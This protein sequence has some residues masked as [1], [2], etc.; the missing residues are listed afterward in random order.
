MPHSNTGPPCSKVTE[1]RISSP[2]M[3]TVIYSPTSTGW[4]ISSLRDEDPN[5]TRAIFEPEDLTCKSF[6]G[7]IDPKGGGSWFL[8]NKNSNAIVLLNG[9]YQNHIPQNNY[10]KSRGLIV[11]ELIQEENPLTAWQSTDLYQIEPFTLVIAA[12]GMLWQAVWDGS[13]KAIATQNSLKAHIWSSST[14]YDAE[15][16]ARRKAHF[17]TWCHTIQNN[18]DGLLMDCYKSLEDQTNG[19]LINRDEQIKTLSHTLFKCTPNMDCKLTY[20]ELDTGM[21]K[22]TA[23]IS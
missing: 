16:K 17:E 15:A 12:G 23:W 13:E 2:N 22:S 11:R 14:L 4:L 10:R 7:P 21:A 5:R 19:F 6:T 3:C 18:D 1:L 9:A 20:T 8:V